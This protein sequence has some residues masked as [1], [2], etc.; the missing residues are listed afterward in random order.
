VILSGSK[1]DLLLVFVQKNMSSVVQYPRN[2]ITALYPFS[3]LKILVRRLRPRAGK[4]CAQ[5][6]PNKGLWK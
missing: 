5:E 3:L 4:W 2:I 6:I 1:F